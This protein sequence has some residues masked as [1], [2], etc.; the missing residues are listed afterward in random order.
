[1]FVNNNKISQFYIP[2]YVQTA[3]GN[4]FSGLFTN[5]HWSF[6]KKTKKRAEKLAVWHTEV[7]SWQLVDEVS[8]KQL[9]N[10]KARFSPRNEKFYLNAL[11]T[12]RTQ[13]NWFG[14]HPVVFTRFEGE[15]PKKKLTL[16]LGTFGL[17]VCSTTVGGQFKIQLKQLDICLITYVSP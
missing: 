10:S 4:S 7:S 3:S 17:T 9:V 5:F 15:V 16:T 11:C 2:R 8:Q 13:K 14:S 12:K 1:M 6:N